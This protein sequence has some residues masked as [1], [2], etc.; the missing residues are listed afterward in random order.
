[1]CRTRSRQ[2][3]FTCASSSDQFKCAV[4]QYLV[5]YQSSDPAIINILN[6]HPTPA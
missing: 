1:M 3:L 5:I 2:P 4:V 6:A